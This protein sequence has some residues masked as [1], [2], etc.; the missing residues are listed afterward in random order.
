MS[1]SIS[2][3]QLDKCLTNSKGN[4]VEPDLIKRSCT[5]AISNIFISVKE[6]GDTG[7]IDTYVANEMREELD[8]SRFPYFL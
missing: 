6:S 1:G 5:R 7:L 2:Q 4:I 3:R 8:S